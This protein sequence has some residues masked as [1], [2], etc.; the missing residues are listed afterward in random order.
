LLPVGPQ[1]NSGLGR[2][3]WDLSYGLSSA[4]HHLGYGSK[5]SAASLGLR[6]NGI[7]LRSCE[8][9]AHDGKIVVVATAF[10]PPR[11]PNNAKLK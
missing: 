7:V 4:P 3:E 10:L 11:N 6:L 9:K 2:P 8:R 5:V 1:V